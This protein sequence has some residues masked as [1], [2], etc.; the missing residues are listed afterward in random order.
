MTYREEKHQS[1]ST[2][3]PVFMG[4]LITS[5]ADDF[6]PNAARS[7]VERR[8]VP[9]FLSSGPQSS[10]AFYFFKIIPKFIRPRFVH[11]FISI[12]DINK[13]GQLS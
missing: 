1:L 10:Q 11:S 13:S 12:I 8:A 4:V 9:S 7:T 2:P 6:L 3:S 5:S